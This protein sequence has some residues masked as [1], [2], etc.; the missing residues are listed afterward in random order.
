MTNQKIKTVGWRH[1]ED[2][3]IEQINPPFLKTLFDS[4]VESEMRDREE[5]EYDDEQSYEDEQLEGEGVERDSVELPDPPNLSRE[6]SLISNFE[7]WMG[8]T[9]FD[10]THSMKHKLSKIEGVEALAVCGRYRFIIGMGQMFDHTDFAKIR[11][12]VEI[13][14][15]KGKQFNGKPKRTDN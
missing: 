3:V 4:L 9:N 14:L 1:Y 5:E 8:Y 2:A 13:M 12:K 6:I 10:I 11:N 15:E 7:C